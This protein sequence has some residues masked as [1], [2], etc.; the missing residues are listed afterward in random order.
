[1][2]ALRQG[3]IPPRK[4]IAEV[5]LLEMLRRERTERLLALE[6][7]I[8]AQ[9]L[10]APKEILSSRFYRHIHRVLAEHIFQTKMSSEVDEQKIIEKVEAMSAD[11]R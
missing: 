3:R 1:M 4:S 10:S 11:H 5:I 8:T 6:A 9:L 7:L 2:Q